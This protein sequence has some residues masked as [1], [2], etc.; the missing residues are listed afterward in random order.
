MSVR[1]SIPSEIYNRI[2]TNATRNKSKSSTIYLPR[3]I[4][5]PESGEELRRYKVNLNVQNELYIKKDGVQYYLDE[6]EDDKEDRLANFIVENQVAYMKDELDDEQRKLWNDLLLREEM[7]GLKIWIDLQNN[8]REHAKLI[9]KAV[10]NSYNKKP[11]SVKER[12]KQLVKSCMDVLVSIIKYDIE[13]LKEKHNIYKDQLT[14]DMMEA[15]KLCHDNTYVFY[16]PRTNHRLKNDA[17]YL[18][19]C[20]QAKEQNDCIQDLVDTVYLCPLGPPEEMID[21]YS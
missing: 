8:N 6:Q 19:Y 1:I 2:K 18:K 13:N 12:T 16:N 11:K 20:E 9:L 4:N 3:N 5:S 10:G 17:A 7:K 21:S 14:T 15:E